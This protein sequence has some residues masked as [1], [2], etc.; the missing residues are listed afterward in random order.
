MWDPLDPN[1]YRGSVLL[2]GVANIVC[3]V[4]NKC[5]MIDMDERFSTLN[6]LFHKK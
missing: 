6:F 2:N 5:Y 3:I 1:N 4:L